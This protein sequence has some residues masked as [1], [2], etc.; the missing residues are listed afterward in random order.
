MAR[1]MPYNAYAQSTR[2]PDLAYTHRSDVGCLL[3]LHSG[4]LCSPPLASPFLYPLLALSGHHHARLSSSQ[5]SASLFR[6]SGLDSQNRIGESL[7]SRTLAARFPPSPPPSSRLLPLSIRLANQFFHLSRRIPLLPAAPRLTASTASSASRAATSTPRCRTYPT[8]TPPLRTR[9]LSSSSASTPPMAP[10]PTL[11]PTVHGHS[12]V[13]SSLGPVQQWRLRV[14]RGVADW[15]G[16]GTR[17]AERAGAATGDSC[18]AMYISIGV[19]DDADADA[20]ADKDAASAGR[21]MV[22]AMRAGM[23]YLWDVDVDAGGPRVHQPLDSRRT[24]RFA[25]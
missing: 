7:Q 2:A 19:G 9:T 4:P 3:A 21:V 6:Y 22:D 18:S 5:L 16:P 11:Q 20:D 23:H 17:R 12:Q 8:P 10:L 14:G 1:E 13:L 24:Q 15:N 25:S